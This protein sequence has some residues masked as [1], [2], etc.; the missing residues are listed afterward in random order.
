MTVT[1]PFQLRMRRL[2]LRPPPGLPVPPTY[3][4]IDGQYMTPAQASEHNARCYKS[5]PVVDLIDY[6]RHDDEDQVLVMWGKCK[7]GATGPATWEPI[8]NIDDN[9]MVGRLFK[10]IGVFEGELQALRDISRL[11]VELQNKNNQLDDALYNLARAQVCYSFPPLSPF[12][13]LT[14]PSPLHAGKWHA[15]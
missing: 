11:Q 1:T 14:P 7:H 12:P 10:R 9:R 13:P 2:P 4:K 3:E 5:W 6:R 8:Q 15:L